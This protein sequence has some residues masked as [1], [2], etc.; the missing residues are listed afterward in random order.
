MFQIKTFT[1]NNK[2]TLPQLVN[3]GKRSLWKI[4]LKP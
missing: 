2:P 1:E 3:S 4:V